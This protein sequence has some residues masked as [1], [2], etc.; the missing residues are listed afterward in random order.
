MKAV[1][2]HG[3]TDCRALWLVANLMEISVLYCVIDFMIKKA[4]NSVMIKLATQ[5]TIV[6]LMLVLG[7]NVR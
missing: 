6:S 2:I 1:L 7:M 5:G 4:T 3:H